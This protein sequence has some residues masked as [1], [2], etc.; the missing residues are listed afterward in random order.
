MMNVLK[1]L[2]QENITVIFSSI[3]AKD[4]SPGVLYH[5]SLHGIFLI[6][7]I[8]SSQ[9]TYFGRVSDTLVF[10]TARDFIDQY[11]EKQSSTSMSG[12]FRGIER[13]S[14]GH[15]AGQNFLRI[16][17][18]V[19][20]GD[21]GERPGEGTG[22]RVGEST[23]GRT[24]MCNVIRQV[25]VRG[26]GSPVITGMYRRLLKRCLKVIQSFC[27][28][29]PDVYALPGCG[30]SDII[31]SVIWEEVAGILD[32]RVVSK[33]GVRNN[34]TSRRITPLQSISLKIC[35][36]LLCRY[37]S[38]RIQV[39]CPGENM[40][41]SEIDRMKKELN[42]SALYSL[43]ELANAISKAYLSVPLLLVKNRMSSL[44]TQPNNLKTSIEVN[45][46]VYL[47]KKHSTSVFT[48]NIYNKNKN[49]LLSIRHNIYGFPIK[50][51]ILESNKTGG[52]HIKRY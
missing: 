5:M 16:S 19:K 2:Q 49:E 50:L 13:I 6:D 33:S 15:G 3:S 39:E 44:T 29:E 41:I 14:M 31:W 7:N 4:M 27:L 46:M 23:E 8:P 12:K 20:R 9:L 38:G 10:D 32:D 1:I 30:I 21:A 34:E 22:D 36:F 37:D 51:G 47:W 35:F 18:V 48:G 43:V 26:C 24:P 17:G 28:H 11:S 52:D 40:I 25:V 42:W 45:R